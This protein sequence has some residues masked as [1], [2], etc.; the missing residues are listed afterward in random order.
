VQHQG[1]HR[2]GNGYV[3]CVGVWRHFISRDSYA[4]EVQQ[5]KRRY[6]ALIALA[7][8]RCEV[9]FAMLRD[10]ILHQRKSAPIA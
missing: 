5:G 9:L 1:R 4:R 8:R 3:F 6:E 10:G 7:R 2:D